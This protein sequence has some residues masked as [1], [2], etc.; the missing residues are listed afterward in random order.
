MAQKG[1]KS[2]TIL[3]KICMPPFYI[4]ISLSTKGT[5]YR[6]YT[7]GP[8]NRLQ[9]RNTGYFKSFKFFRYLL[10]LDFTLCPGSSDP[11]WN[12]ESNYFSNWI[13]VT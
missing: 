13:H 4:H 6:F 5:V 1:P 10:P 2:D 11:T 7:K 12:I 3:F 9:L 8:G